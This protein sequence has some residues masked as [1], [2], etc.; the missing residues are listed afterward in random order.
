MPSIFEKQK[1]N[2]DAI[3]SEDALQAI[4]LDWLN[5]F[6]TL[7]RFAEY[8]CLSVEAASELVEVCR[9]VHENRT[10]RRA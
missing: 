5:N 7:E 8:Y 3:T 9:S 2:V 10:E 1:V 6:L 4:Y